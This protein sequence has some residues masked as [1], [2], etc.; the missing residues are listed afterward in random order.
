MVMLVLMDMVVEGIIIVLVMGIIMGLV[1]VMVG[2][3]IMVING[4]QIDNFYK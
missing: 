3:G 1:V 4:L 2:M